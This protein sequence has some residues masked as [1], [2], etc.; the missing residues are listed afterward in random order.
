MSARRNREGLR[1]GAPTPI[2]YRREKKGV[3]AGR[4]IKQ[5]V[6][7]FSE[8]PLV[9]VPNPVGTIYPNP[10]LERIFD[11][12]SL[13][14]EL[15][16]A[17][18]KDLALLLTCEVLRRTK[19]THAD[20][21]LRRLVQSMLKNPNE[22]TSYD[23]EFVSRIASIARCTH[24][25]VEETIAKVRN[26]GLSVSGRLF[27][28]SIGWA[29][30]EHVG[31][32]NHSC[33]PNVYLYFKLDGSVVLQAIRDIGEGQEIH[34]AY[35][36]G[37]KYGPLETRRNNLLSIGGFDCKCSRC[38]EAADGS[39]PTIFLEPRSSPVAVSD[40][41]HFDD[42]VAG[43]VRSANAILSRHSRLPFEIS[44]EDY[45]DRVIVAV[46]EHV[47]GVSLSYPSSFR[48]TAVLVHLITHMN[49][50]LDGS[51][52]LPARLELLRMAYPILLK[53]E[54]LS[55][56]PIAVAHC[57]VSQALPVAVLAEGGLGEAYSAVIHRIV[58]EGPIEQDFRLHMLY[59]AFAYTLLGKNLEPLSEIEKQFRKIRG[60]WS[61]DIVEID[62]AAV[63]GL[64]D[65]ME[66]NET[67]LEEFLRRLKKKTNNKKKRLRAKKRTVGGDNQPTEPEI[68]KKPSGMKDCS[69]TEDFVTEDTAAVTEVVASTSELERTPSA[70]ADDAGSPTTSEDA[71]VEE[72]DNDL[73]GIDSPAVFEEETT[74]SDWDTEGPEVL[75]WKSA[76]SAELNNTGAVPLD[77][78][79]DPHANIV[80]QDNQASSCESRK[81]TFCSCC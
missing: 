13:K 6:V 64:N 41:D 5:G 51:P 47:F 52:S 24:S 68:R 35:L 78:V 79:H 17:V 50:S 33:E 60:M 23:A 71:E 72:N 44:E 25:E 27:D 20:L 69:E 26:H 12:F 16:S 76:T 55:A 59:Q 80:V 70:V 1:S 48:H 11:L 46:F 22:L 77:S 36:K 8:K 65:V 75:Y 54:E 30:Y 21:K 81:P 67:A 31:F 58:K 9:F 2:I 45:S 42:V 38:A 4:D 29:L 37:R 39:T 62:C 7:F 34:C 61:R 43:V 19:Q 32:L 57:F 10:L 28:S 49:V 15:K 3:F 73:S 53:T 56:L 40:E 18:C 66:E 74:D 63:R 14:E